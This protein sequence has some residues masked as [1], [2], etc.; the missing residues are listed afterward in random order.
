MKTSLYNWLVEKDSLAIAF[1]GFTGSL[2]EI[3]PEH[4]PLLRSLCCSSE[5]GLSQTEISAIDSELLNQLI[6]GGYILDSDFDER[7]YLKMS[8]NAIR[9]SGYVSTIVAVPTISCN[10][11]CSYCFEGAPDQNGPVMTSAVIDAIAEE[12]SRAPIFFSLTLYGGEPLLALEECISIIQKCRSALKEGIGFHCTM[13]SNGYLLDKNTSERLCEAGLS[14]VQVTIDGTESIHDSR[15]TLKDGK[16]TYRRIVENVRSSACIFPGG[17][18]VRVNC[19]YNNLDEVQRVE[20]EFADIDKATVYY[21]PTRYDGLGNLG[22]K[23]IKNARSIVDND[24]VLASNMKTNLL[25]Q[26]VLACNSVLLNGM[27]VLPDG[28]ILRCMEEVNKPN[29]KPYGNILEGG[30]SHERISHIMT[31]DPYSPEY[32]CWNCK[33]LPTCGCGCPKMF[34]ND[35]TDECASEYRSGTEERI[36]KMYKHMARGG[37]K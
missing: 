37:E 3:E 15:R 2:A 28:N 17:I 13:I 6:Y 31:F 30:L 23:T 27:L 5:K 12:A 25:K 10:F 7:E 35:K 21:A 1:N 9:Y 34:S 26:R 14:F 29:V 22:Y 32:P 8:Y 18:N 4:I 20:K 19:D 16:P 33:S 36:W 11:K 24:S